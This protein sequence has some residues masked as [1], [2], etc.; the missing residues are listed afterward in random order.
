V[1]NM[2]KQETV[3]TR[4]AVLL[5]DPSLSL[6]LSLSLT[7]RADDWSEHERAKR[8]GFAL[9]RWQPKK[10]FSFLPQAL[11]FVF[12]PRSRT[13]CRQRWIGNPSMTLAKKTNDVA[14][15]RRLVLTIRSTVVNYYHP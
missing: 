7:F 15:Y 14:F 8:S 13:R 4:A 5:R 2:Y 12:G 9:P 10:W 6:S 3:H 1:I 11:S